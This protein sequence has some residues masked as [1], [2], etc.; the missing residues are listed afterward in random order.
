MDTKGG[1][2]IIELELI[3]SIFG[4][5]SISVY[6]LIYRYNESKKENIRMRCIKTTGPSYEFTIIL[7][8][9]EEIIEISI[10]Q[11]DHRAGG[12]IYPKDNEKLYKILDRVLKESY[13]NE[14]TIFLEGYRNLERNKD[15]DYTT[16][17]KTII[18]PYEIAKEWKLQ[19]NNN[20]LVN[21]YP[22]IFS[23]GWYD[24]Y[25]LPQAKFRINWEGYNY[26][27]CR[28]F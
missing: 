26:N 8:D 22:F 17:L 24:E 10:E 16:E 13:I 12:Y 27:N 28:R 3:V 15:K 11:L 5:I 18:Q 4:L 9:N 23:G 6:Y 2:Q 20:Y 7:N 1:K 19:S 14:E 25:C 21:E